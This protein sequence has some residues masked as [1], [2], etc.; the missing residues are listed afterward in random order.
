M[1]KGLGG[2]G[3]WGGKD[4]SVPP[5]CVLTSPRPLWPPAPWGLPPAM[6]ASLW[7]LCP[8]QGHITGLTGVMEFREDRS[9]PYV[10]FE[11]LGTTY[12]ETFGKDMRKVSAG[13]AR[14][15]RGRGR[16]SET[17]DQKERVLL[18]CPPHSGAQGGRRATRSHRPGPANA[19]LCVA[20]G[21]VSSGPEWTGHEREG[22]Q[23]G[24]RRAGPW[25]GNGHAAPNSGFVHFIGAH[26]RGWPGSPWPWP[27]VERGAGWARAGIPRLSHCW[28]LTM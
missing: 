17:A 10:Q 26:A 22:E 8:L 21:S 1:S 20:E 19:A 3:P 12:S 16:S 28:V 6:S 13:Q 23:G 7:M 5:T 4:G 15:A 18:L 11:I 27:Q 2:A 24:A 14:G 25:R 9:N